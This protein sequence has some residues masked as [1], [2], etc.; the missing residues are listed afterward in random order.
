MIGWTNTYKL[1]IRT[2]LGRGR[3]PF[4]APPLGNLLNYGTI[5]YF[6]NGLGDRLQE[7]VNGV[8]TTFTMDLASNLT[9]V[10]DDGTTNYIYGVDRIAQKIG[11]D[12]EYFLGDALGSVRQLADAG[13]AI[14]LPTT[15]TTPRDPLEEVS[16]RRLADLK[17]LGVDGKGF[18]VDLAQALPGDG[19]PVEAGAVAFVTGEAITGVLAVG[20]AHDGIPGGLGQDGGAGYAEGEAITFNE[21]GLIPFELGKKEVIGKKVIRN[22]VIR[23]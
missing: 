15:W 20:E 8:T 22:Q 23:G 14:S 3:N 4:H 16:W 2:F 6:Y 5:T 11:G 1:M 19:L 13:G 9:Q 17:P 21:G 12:T 10:L 18:A 7:T